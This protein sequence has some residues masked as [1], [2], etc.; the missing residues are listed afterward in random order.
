MKKASFKING[1]SC[2]TYSETAKDICFYSYTGM[3]AEDIDQE[4][5]PRVKEKHAIVAWLKK[6]FADAQKREGKTR[7]EKER[8]KEKEQSRKRSRTKEKKGKR[9]KDPFTGNKQ[10]MRDRQ[11]N[12]KR[13][14]APPVSIRAMPEIVIPPALRVDYFFDALI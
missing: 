6:G 14:Y 11:V 13:T 4:E 12:H 3:W 1:I 7:I 5:I 2:N 8:E 9:R 10:K